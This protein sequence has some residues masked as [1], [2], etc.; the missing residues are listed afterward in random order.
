MSWVS[1]ITAPLAAGCVSAVAWVLPAPAHADDSGFM[2]YLNS[3]GYTARYA[4]DEPI[5]EPSVRALGHMI[6]ENLRVG[7]SV[8]AQQPN[9]PA[10]PQFTLIA[11]AAQHELCPG[12]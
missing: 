11:E 7:R 1:R 3:H 6:C 2:K 8:E 4:G 9:Y 12:V 5:S 10:W